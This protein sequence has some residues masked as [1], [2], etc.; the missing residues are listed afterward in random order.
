VFVAVCHCLR[1]FALASSLLLVIRLLKGYRYNLLVPH[2]QAIT[3]NCSS[4]IA[5]QYIHS[6]SFYPFPL[7]S[8][9]LQDYTCPHFF[10]VTKNRFGLFSRCIESPRTTVPPRTKDASGSGIGAFICTHDIIGAHREG[11]LR[12]QSILSISHKPLVY[13]W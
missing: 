12:L 6:P 5:P 11:L 3:Y 13:V 10:A 9:S 4:L 8:N 7:N 1:Y 2:P